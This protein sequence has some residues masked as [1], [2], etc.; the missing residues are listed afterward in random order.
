MNLHQ[1]RSPV[2]AISF[3][4]HFTLIELLVVIAIIA[5][6]AAML[7]PS[8]QRARMTA[9]KTNC[10][11]TLKSIGSG[12]QFYAD[13]WDGT[14]TARDF[15]R[16]WIQNLSIYL[17]SAPKSWDGHPTL[18]DMWNSKSLFYTACKGVVPQVPDNISSLNFSCYGINQFPERETNFFATN[19][20]GIDNFKWF[21]VGSITHPSRRGLV[22]ETAS[23]NEEHNW[24]YGFG[25]SGAEWQGDL[26]NG[27]NVDD[28]VVDFE[29]HADRINLLFYDLHV[30]EGQRFR[31][32]TFG[33]A[34][35]DPNKFV[36]L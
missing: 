2:P 8:L 36:A 12:H 11:N 35:Y 6:L 14:Y 18:A 29:R 34:F 13:D 33:A 19:Q 22:S 9:H 25:I 15:Q 17:E 16:M 4:H 28:S 24:P 30:G 26:N 27:I 3:R 5:I 23:S 7:L 10:K 32:V 20:Y 31:M 1:K 21:R